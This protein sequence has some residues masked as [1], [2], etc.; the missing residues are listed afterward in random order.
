MSH[1]LDKEHLDPQNWEDA[2]ALMHRMVDDAI[3]YLRDI[4][5]RPTWQEMPEEVT[6]QFET[7]YPLQGTSAEEVY[8]DLKDWVMPY[9]MGNIHPKFWAWYMGAGTWSGAVGD[10]WASVINPNLGGAMHSGTMVER[11]VIQWMKEMMG[12]P[13]ESSGLLGQWGVHGQFR[14]PRRRSPFQSRLQPSK[15]RN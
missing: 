12:F 11:Q 6:K 3:D 4:R 10:F 2:R 5:Q 14:W 9:A 1:N 15:R 8:Q 13:Q 7:Q